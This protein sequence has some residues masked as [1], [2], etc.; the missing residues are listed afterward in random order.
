MGFNASAK[1]ID[2]GQ[3]TQFVQADLGQYFLLLVDCSAFQRHILPLDSVCCYTKWI[4]G[5][6]ML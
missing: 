4:S 1:I 3:A 2:P 6:I 5:S